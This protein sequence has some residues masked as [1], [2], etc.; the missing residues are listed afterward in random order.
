[1]TLQDAQKED[2]I[3]MCMP[4]TQAK[5]KTKHVEGWVNFKIVQNKKQLLCVT[6]KNALLSAGR[7]T[8]Y[9]FVF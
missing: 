6:R 9:F 3:L 1:C 5:K 2:D 7:N 4:G 8:F